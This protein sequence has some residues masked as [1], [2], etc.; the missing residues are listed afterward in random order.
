MLTSSVL[1][2][3][4]P[5]HGFAFFSCSEL[6]VMTAGAVISRTNREKDLMLPG[7]EYR[8]KAVLG[9]VKYAVQSTGCRIFCVS[10]LLMIR[11]FYC[12]QNQFL[13]VTP[14]WEEELTARVSSSALVLFSS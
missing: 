4:L 2:C 10:C 9:E 12:L 11:M 13:G 3:L 14:L 5:N 1:V 6:F 8:F 7:L